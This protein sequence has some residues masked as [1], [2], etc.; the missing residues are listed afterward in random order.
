MES[1][2]LTLTNQATLTGLKN[3]PPP[4]ERQLKRL[5][6]FVA[7]HGGTYTSAYYDVDANHTASLTS[8]GLGVPFIAINRPCYEDSTSYYPLPAASSFHQEFGTWLH[9]YILP[10]LWAEFGKPAG[11]N[12]I[13]LDSHSLGVPGAVIAA[14]MHAEESAQGVRPQYPLAG[15]ILSGFGTQVIEEE[16][17]L[18]DPKNPP[19]VINFPSAAKDM[20]MLPPG[21]CDPELYKHTD[22]LNRPMPY[23][24]IY[25]VR[26]LWL[27]TWKEMWAKN[28]KV[29]VMIGLA[30]ND[31][32]W[33]G[34]KDHVKDFCAAF[35]NSV[36]VDGSVVVGAPHNIEQSHWGRGWFARCFGFAL[37]SAA[38]HGA[39]T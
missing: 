26:T 38:S 33:K 34:T 1:F 31:T 13:V 30:E 29:P 22:R 18:A 24:E 35:P 10:T 9:R 17:R 19:K 37:E 39:S 8:N 4:S 2:N 11:C 7:I 25:E 5:P 15:I 36:R 14:S 27:P 21:S 12:S 20:L 16:F 28:V 23:D 3:I 6:L 32:L